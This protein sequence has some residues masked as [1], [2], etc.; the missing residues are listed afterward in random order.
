[1]GGEE[2]ADAG[3][4][5]RAAPLAGGALLRLG[6]GSLRVEDGRGGTVL[7]IDVGLVRS[8]VAPDRGTVRV[9]W[10]GGGGRRYYYDARL[11]LA[12][13]H[14]EK[15]KRRLAARTEADG[16][17]RLIV[18]AAQDRNGNPDR[19]AG[20][21]RLA[22]RAGERLRYRHAARCRFGAGDLY[23][24]SAGAYF[25]G[26]RAGLCLDLPMQL[27][28]SCSASGRTVRLRYGEPGGGGGPAP[29]ART[30]ELRVPGADARGVCLE[31]E[32]AREAGGG[33]D[34]RRLAEYA[35]RYGRMDPD[36][37][38]AEYYSGRRGEEKPINDYARLLAARR[39]DAAYGRFT[40]WDHTV[41]VASMLSG[42]PLEAAGDLTDEDRRL[43]AR[44]DGFARER[45]EYMGKA[46]PLVRRLL[47]AQAAGL[48]EAD[49][50]AV[51]RVPHWAV[52][53]QMLQE[54]ARSGRIPEGFEP[55]MA[56]ELRRVEGEVNSRAYAFQRGPPFRYAG[57]DELPRPWTADGAR[58][59][60]AD[61][62]YVEAAGALE[63]LGGEGGPGMLDKMTPDA[64]S[65]LLGEELAGQAGV[66]IR[67]LYDAWAEGVP[68]AGPDD[69]RDPG[70]VEYAAGRI[71]A[72]KDEARRRHMGYGDTLAGT[73]R[74][75]AALSAAR[76]DRMS[77]Q[78]LP[79]ARPADAFADAWYD[80]PRR[81]WFS[82]SDC[83]LLES[84]GPPHMGPGECER[85][86]GVRARGFR[87]GSV[88]MMHGLPAARDGESGRWALL[89]TV[90]D[91][92][93][94]AGMAADRA[95]RLLDY[96][97]A[98][99]AVSLA[100]TGLPA[101]FTEAELSAVTG[102]EKEDAPPGTVAR[103]LASGMPLLPFR[104][105]MR[106]F[107]FF[108]ECGWFQVAST[109][110]LDGRPAPNARR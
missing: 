10:H 25:V 51:R 75:A 39:W 18:R 16:L 40:L 32:G 87:R 60:L 99:P 54:L 30:A 110:A 61:P 97:T 71:D 72:E 6:G 63:R 73:L 9:S 23:I 83:A 28:A 20:G 42:V 109:A 50:G 47:G 24:T 91:G 38:H 68:L 31:L 101:R 95:A 27:L 1:M 37:L 90:E 84:A 79:A 69:P 44:L 11:D 55:P 67:R 36:G 8:A 35:H 65:L 33:G 2:G 102:M 88:R 56:A 22:L 48:P 78:A 12:R 98:E 66:R 45:D 105:R 7:E 96:S 19:A 41:V 107:L 108:V 52:S 57:L 89:S 4:P 70:W 76:K 93:V 15:A 14:P 21:G 62:D 103:A 81:A 94:T 106:R 86:I 26:E 43:R 3:A 64:L 92:M 34:E 77:R 58:R 104:E 49:A 46:A 29:R 17:A 80:A 100:N 85:E 13:S 82:A 53:H 5:A 59:V 74:S